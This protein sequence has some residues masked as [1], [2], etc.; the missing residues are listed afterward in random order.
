MTVIREDRFILTH[1]LREQGSPDHGVRK[2]SPSFQKG[3]KSWFQGIQSILAGKTWLK[4]SE[5]FS[6]SLQGGHN[7]R[8]VL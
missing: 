6:P 5:R 2:Y 3:Q 7:S 1:S 4:G 8:A